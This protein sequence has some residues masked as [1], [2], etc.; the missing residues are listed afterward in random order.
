[1][2]NILAAASAFALSLS[3]VLA[4]TAPPA[5]AAAPVEQQSELGGGLSVALI[6]AIVAIGAALYFVVD[7]GDSPDSP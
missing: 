5:R 1:M 7:G 3:P 6:I 4:Q 2:R